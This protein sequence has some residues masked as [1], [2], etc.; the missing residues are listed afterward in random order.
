[1]NYKFGTV[2]VVSNSL[3]LTG[4]D[5]RG[6]RLCHPGLKSGSKWNDLFAQYLEER[7]APRNCE[8]ELTVFEDRAK[9][10]ANFFGDSCK[11]G[12][13]VEDGTED[14]W[15]KN[16]YSKLCSICEMG[17]CGNSE[18]YRGSAGSLMCLT[19]G[20]GEVLW[21]RY[22]DVK[23][24]FKK[25][26]SEG[27]NIS[28][29]DYSFLCE[30][31]TLKPLDTSDPCLWLAMPWQVVAANRKS[32]NEVQKLFY[33]FGSSEWERNLVE[34]I[35]SYLHF[36]VNL[37]VS[38]TPEDFLKGVPGY[39]SALE[40]SQG[41]CRPEHSVSLCTY[42]PADQ[43]KCD[44]MAKAALSVALQP[45]LECVEAANVSSCIEL[46]ANGSLDVV[47]VPPDYAMDA[48]T[49]YGLSTLFYEIP[50]QETEG[51]VLSAY[52][53]ENSTIK[54]LSDLSSKR[55]CFTRVGGVGWNSA[56]F[57][58][59]KIGL[60]DSS[61]RG[62][63][64]LL[65][66]FRDVCVVSSTGMDVP[67]C[68]NR[69]Q[70]GESD[71]ARAINCLFEGG[72][73]VAFVD[74]HTVQA[75]IGKFSE[76]AEKKEYKSKSLRAICPGRKSSNCWYW[77]YPNYLMFNSQASS[78]KFQEMSSLFTQI[79]EVFGRK[80]K[81]DNRILEIFGPFS[82]LKNVLFK[83]SESDGFRDRGVRLLLNYLPFQDSS[84]AFSKKV[85]LEPPNDYLD[86]LESLDECSAADHVHGS[87]RF[88]FISFLLL[89]SYLY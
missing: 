80:S 9:T 20:V 37:Q 30:D 72:C 70:S 33:D 76:D 68:C 3:N 52:A 54:S 83:A 84:V 75:Q 34:V 15:L 4:V 6:K 31:G 24:Y 22:D 44:W 43:S 32:T 86:V 49:E 87:L 55:A 40:M 7:L 21:A 47:V 10:S 26:S 60:I 64:S 39:L 48:R 45:R 50:S 18:K 5:L 71:G 25:F 69:T 46:V 61:C 59:K 11:A 19:D 51:Y 17:D 36:I 73:D 16:E 53:K 58:F 28:P 38:K 29:L 13:W 27:S 74:T 63:E 42:S 78:V 77:S 88:L 23:T 2:V 89:V 41:N 85:E 81:A 14:I 56:L 82:G 35:E 12:P 66:F 67:I 57:T 1:M 79:G 65:N 62:K 8:P